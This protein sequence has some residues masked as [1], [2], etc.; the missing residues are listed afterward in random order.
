MRS[1]STLLLTFV[2]L[3]MALSVYIFTLKSGYPE[4]CEIYL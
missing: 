1:K 2:L 3:Q 4:K